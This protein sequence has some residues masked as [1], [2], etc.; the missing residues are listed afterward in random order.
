MNVCLGVTSASQLQAKQPSQLLKEHCNARTNVSCGSKSYKKVGRVGFVHGFSGVVWFSSYP[1]IGST[2]L[3]LLL[4]SVHPF[5]RNVQAHNVTG[6]FTL[7][8]QPT[9]YKIT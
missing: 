7:L 6:S 8:S 4:L 3:G 5:S 2:N 1:L 9:A